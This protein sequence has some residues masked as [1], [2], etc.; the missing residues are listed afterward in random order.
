MIKLHLYNRLDKAYERKNLYLKELAEAYE[1]EDNIKVKDIKSNKKNHNYSIQLKEYK[2]KEKNFL[3]ALKQEVKKLEVNK[4]KRLN[5]LE[6]R[7]YK[8][9]KMKEFY[10]KYIDFCYDAEYF[11]NVS[12]FEVKEI[13]KTI[14]NITFIENDI[15]KQKEVVMNIKSSDS[16][17]TKENLKK[18]KTEQKITLKK[19]VAVVKKKLHDK[20]ISPKAYSNSVKELKRRVKENYTVK[21]Y[22]LPDVLEK[23]KLKN[24]YFDLKTEYKKEVAYINE[25]ISEIRRNTPV[26]VDKINK[27]TYLAYLFPGIGQIINGQKTKGKLMLLLSVFVYLMAIPYALGFGNYRGD[28]ISGLISLAEGAGKLDRSIIF[29]IEGVIALFLVAI[30][31]AVIMFNIKDIKNQVDFSD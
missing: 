30:A 19:K 18:F 4:S 28:G 24:N 6:I 11:Y 8:A 9:Q 1:S 5:N 7:Y 14:K 10:E 25:N 26:E 12:T 23:K 27:F 17:E 2:L 13:P 22:E 16:I 20:I 3:R 29:M 15:I 31:V 21:T